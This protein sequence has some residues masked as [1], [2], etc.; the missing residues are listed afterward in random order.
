MDLTVSNASQFKVKEIV[1][2]TKAGSIDITSIFAEINI[3]D[4]LFMPVITGNIVIIDSIGLSSR[5]FFD[6]SESILLHLSKDDQSDI[7][8]YKRAFRIY[9]QTNRTNQNQNTE[10]YTLH[11]VSDEQIFSDQQRIN[12]SFNTTYSDMVE[13]I[14]LNYLKVKENNLGGIYEI[15]NGLRKVVIPNLRPLE[16]IEWCAKRAVDKENSPNFVFFQNSVG[17]NFVSLSTLLTQ[18]TILNINFSVKNRVDIDSINELSS[19]IHLEIVSQNDTLENTR[20]GVY[21]GKFIGFDPITRSHAFRNLSYGDHYTS[22]RHG[23]ETPNFTSIQNRDKAYNDQMFNSKKTL[24]IFGT[25]RRYSKYIKDNDPDSINKT[26][27]YENVVFQRTSI[28]K[29][30]MNKKIK[31]VMPGN[32]QLSSGFNVGVTSPLFGLKS[33]DESTEDESISGNYLIV[34]SRQI[35]KFD[36]HETIIEVASSS[37]KNP[38]VF[39]SN[40]NQ[41]EAVLNY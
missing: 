25:T 17:F 2:V 23:N 21:A 14:L 34:A 33:N 19:A 12:Q 16:A 24:S 1:L 4:S 8:E 31:L 27:D 3:F 36:R 7:A 35:I 38:F 6:G 39:E 41:T 22:M 11:F 32:F 18:D 15:T 40:P 30:L 28:L 29:N 9:K 13:K 20:S 37:N 5:I 26:Q 10:S